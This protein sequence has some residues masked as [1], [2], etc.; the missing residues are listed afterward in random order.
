[1][2][3]ISKLILA[4][5]LLSAYIHAQDSLYVVKFDSSFVKFGINE[6]KRITFI[7]PQAFGT[8]TDMEGHVYHWITIGTQTWMVENL[9]TS[10]YRSGESIK[11]ITDKTEWGNLLYTAKTPGWCYYN[12]D[13]AKDSINGKLYNWFAVS[14]QRNIAPIGWHVASGSEWLQL[15]DY[16][17]NNGYNYDGS[18]ATIGNKLAKTIASSFGWTEST[19]EGAPG[20]NQSKNNITGFSAI[21]VGVRSSDGSF[22]G[23]GN[24]TAWWTS[25]DASNAVYQKYQACAYNE[26]LQYDNSYLQEGQRYGQWNTYDFGFSVRC[27]K[28]DYKTSAPALT[29]ELYS[30]TEN[31]A[32]ILSRITDYGNEP[33]LRY[34]NTTSWQSGICWSDKPTPTLADNIVR[35]TDPSNM[36]LNLVVEKG[37]KY[38]VRAFATNTIGTGYSNEIIVENNTV[39]VI[40]P[41][42]KTD[43]INKL[44]TAGASVYGKIESNGG[45][46][47]TAK[48]FC[49]STQASPTI[50]LTT[51][52]VI[53]GTT[54]IFSSL[55]TGLIPNTTYYVRAYA[56]NSAGTGYGDLIEFKTLN[57]SY[58]T[59]TDIEGNVYNTVKIGTKEWMV[60]DLRTTKYRNGDPI[61]NV[62]N[63]SE[64]IILTNGA[65][66]AYNNSLNS[67]SIT[68]F[69][70]LYNYYAVKDTRNIAPLGWH[71]ATDDDWNSLE[72]YLIANGFNYDGTTT[73]NKFAK[74]LAAKS[75]WTSST[76][77]GSIGNDL[78]I[79][80]KSFFNALPTGFRN[81]GGT[82]YNLGKLCQWWSSTEINDPTFQNIRYVFYQNPDLTHTIASK[83]CGNSVRCVRD[84]ISLPYISTSA[85]ASITTN[86]AMSGGIITNDGGASVIARGICWSTT[87]NPTI[88]NSKTTDG[89]GVG[90][91]S[92]L[93]SGLTANTTYY[94]RAYATNSIGTVY[95]NQ[96]EFKTIISSQTMTDIE[97]NVYHTVKIGTKEWMVEDLRTTKYRNGDPIPNVTNNSEW[98]ILTNGAQ[99]AYN[100]SL[101]SDSITKFGRLYNYYAVKDT[102]NIAPLGW[103][104]A[105]DD[106]WNSLETYLIANGFN[107]DGTTTGN[108]FAKSLAA[109]S[110]WT[111][112]TVIGSIGNDLSINDK[113]FFNALP[114]G[115]RNVGGTYYNLGKLCQWWSSTEIN[116][117]TFQNIRYVF[118]QNPDLT[119]TIASK[120]CGNSV[121]CVR[122]D[123]SLPTLIT[124]VIS[125]V[126]STTA[127]GGG[128]ITSDGGASI[129]ARGVCWSTSA[130]PT[131]ANSKISQGTG[132]GTFTCSIT[133]L[134]PATT[135]Y[136]RAFATNSVGTSYGEIQ[137]CKPTFTT[138]HLA[139]GTI[140]DIDGNTYNTITIGNQTW[141][142][143][144]L[145]TTHY[146]N[147]EAIINVPD[148]LTWIN[149]TYG[150]Y[151][152]YGNSSKA[153]M[154][155]NWFAASDSRNIAPVG[156]HVPT[157][158]DLTTL[159]T[160][161]G[162]AEVAGEKMKSE[163]FLSNDCYSNNLSGFSGLMNGWRYNG[164]F[165]YAGTLSGWWTSTLSNPS[166]AYSLNLDNGVVY[167]MQGLTLKKVGLN[168]RCVK[169]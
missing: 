105:T 49:W 154:F 155:Y 56:T 5:L 110:D 153:G 18:A 133:G 51:K 88:A 120:I 36:L 47:I 111:S 161:L 113:S 67:D 35:A 136:Y 99:C 141:M 23:V 8:T 1:M 89:I 118:Y 62:T 134:T 50:D 107:Y 100:N 66:C 17:K 139:T 16:L 157:N 142:M 144:D 29:T 42:V 116:D 11:N 112:S 75:D 156:W 159:L 91:F 60:Q 33:I 14:D 31:V 103:H 94:V 106:D 163:T 96:I 80:D 165:E 123:V 2:K 152:N 71:V 57:I 122:D 104:V 83:I 87:V 69:G 6:I 169:D 150:A 148:S 43:S 37:K 132:T 97:G 79:N 128:N 38:Y 86:S 55:L 131:I 168:I 117:P 167:A 73:G 129:T 137:I 164:K 143:E 58:Q 85:V 121:R 119:H 160:Y 78:S 74:S 46:D 41:T 138:N 98:I 135:Y 82:Y 126:T 115:F 76:V 22:Y 81:V 124:S 28:N 24:T 149:A 108:K 32:K 127:I 72:T 70:R 25:T 130:N 19:V 45:A 109:K 147:G 13:S 114:T 30:L 95:G 162:G 21:P 92:S 65:Q 26:G 64:W 140:T 52:T 27:I 10:K 158:S 146:R 125:S 9:R 101:N 166:D 63:N 102:R 145:R 54:D 151:S 39:S 84:D 77:I 68:K 93:I 48:G 61:P 15:I 3:T 12:N 20:N 40:I 7:K 90:T 34:N 44:S 53:S 59:I 4:F